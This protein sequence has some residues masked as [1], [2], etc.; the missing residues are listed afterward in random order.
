MSG[1]YCRKKTK[2]KTFLSSQCFL[3]TGISSYR[4]GAQFGAPQRTVTLLTRAVTKSVKQHKR[5]GTQGT[6]LRQE[7]LGH[8]EPDPDRSTWDT[9]ASRHKEHD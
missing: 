6:R 2:K 7:Q 5:L 4:Q 9:R 1:L 8:K 3:V